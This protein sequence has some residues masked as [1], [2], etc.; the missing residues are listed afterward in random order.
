MEN[1]LLPKLISY[2]KYSYITCPERAKLSLLHAFPGVINTW[3][4]P[5][6]LAGKEA[7]RLLAC[8]T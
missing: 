8:F 1:I 7:T 2:P 6:F 5:K 3:Y 4:V